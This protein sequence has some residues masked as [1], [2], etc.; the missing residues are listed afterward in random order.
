MDLKT[1]DQLRI[2]YKKHNF[3]S[4]ENTFLR[5]TLFPF[6]CW[7]TVCEPPEQATPETAEWDKKNQPKPWKNKNIFKKSGIMEWTRR[8]YL[9]DPQ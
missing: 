9:S 4:Q 1:P 2:C 6:D 7:D 5:Y 8:H 3:T